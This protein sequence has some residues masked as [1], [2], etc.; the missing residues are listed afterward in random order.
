MTETRESSASVH[1]HE[2]VS[3]E[4]LRKRC[5][6]E[7]Y[8]PK[9]TPWSVLRD[10]FIAVEHLAFGQELS[11]DDTTI[12]NDMQ[13]PGTVAVLMRDSTTQELVGFVY[14]RPTLVVYPERH[15]E[16][17][18]SRD[19]AYICDTALLPNY[20]G[21]GLVGALVTRLE[22]ELEHRDYKFIE[23]D[24]SDAKNPGSNESYADKVR[25]NYSDR[26]VKEE[27]HESAFGPQVF[28][29]IRLREDEDPT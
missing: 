29:R 8:D 27:K 23:R 18:G 10:E 26:I 28:F 14:A 24:S 11:F 17:D 6:V 21:H 20:Q 16:R 5:Y 15:P 25:K 22:E 12:D 4:E 2:D 7:V 19:T 13:H 9:V 1:F 3:T